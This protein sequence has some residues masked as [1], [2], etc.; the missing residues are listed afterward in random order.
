VTD[1]PTWTILIPTLGQRAA[2]FERLM[3]VLLPQLEPHEGRVRVVA[4]WNNGEPSLASIRQAM[5]QETT[6]DYVSFVDDDDLVPE[7]FVDEVMTALSSW[8][9]Y[10]GWQTH[11]TSNGVDHGLVDH[12]LR[13]GGWAERKNP[14]ALLRDITHINPMRTEVAKRGDFRKGARL[15][16]PEDRPWVDQIRRTG[17]LQTEVYVDKVMYEYLWRNDTSAWRKPSRIDRRP[18]VRPV[19]DSPYFS[20]HPSS[21][22]TTAPIMTARTSSGLSTARGDSMADLLIII[23]TRGRP[24]NMRRVIDAWKATN[25][26]EVATVLFAIDNDDPERDAY[27]A[28]IT[29]ADLDLGVVITQADRL[30]MAPRTNAEAAQAADL[31]FALGSAG[32]DHV[33]E[34][35]GWAQR[36]L[37]ELRDMRAG[38]VYG[39]D[40]FQGAK[41]CTEWAMTSNI[42]T[43]LGGRLVPAPVDHLY[44]D[45]SVLELGKG[46]T[47]IKHLADVKIRHVHPVAGHGSWNEEGYARV[48]AKEKYAKDGAIFQQWRKKG[49]AGDASLVRSLGGRRVDQTRLRHRS[50]LGLTRGGNIQSRPSTRLDPNRRRKERPVMSLPRRIRDVRGL[51]SDDAM[52]ALADMAI[53]VP[54]EHAIVEL[55]V[56]QGKTA[57][58]MAWGAAQG[59]GAHVYGV[60]PW[61]LAESASEHPVDPRY[62]KWP[63]FNSPGARRWAEWNVKALGYSSKVTLIQGFSAEVGKQW[64]GPPVG[65]LFVDGDHRYHAVLADVAAWEPHLVHGATV[66]ID[67]Y[68]SSH[69]EVIKA[70]NDLVEA[71]VLEP[72]QIFHGRMAVTRI[73]PWKGP[74][75]APE[76]TSTVELGTEVVEL[77]EADSLLDQVVDQ[78]AKQPAPEAEYEPDERLIVMPKEAEALGDTGL[79]GARIEE[80]NLA[81]LKALAKARGIVLGARKDKKDLI[82]DALR[83]GQ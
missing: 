8:P 10:V 32:D 28:E 45:N 39:D 46:A 77:P 52:L 9:D 57:L 7:Y 26:F 2:L 13:H 64:G 69:P 38:I 19:V 31:F 75:S 24:Q 16:K 80:L 70:V 74:L 68:E 23:P 55:G 40:G 33:P 48:N 5:V 50:G 47:C 29:D 3:A 14:Y 76:V 44:A 67:D 72:V 1:G 42:V 60:D 79:Q 71:G 59:A 58:A 17:L 15:G 49:L 18:S 82:L 34:T 65:L 63:T 12:S 62:R 41:L 56:Y 61:E 20:W 36:Y 81:Q 25:A 54:A 73:G 66:V 27:L 51:T 4:W 37:A 43:A 53:Q 11:Y 22:G 30:P 78:D 21:A 35:V 83:A 6:S